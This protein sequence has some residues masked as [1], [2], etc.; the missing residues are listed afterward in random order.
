M[1]A[2]IAVIKTRRNL[3]HIPFHCITYIDLD[4]GVVRYTE[5]TFAINLIAEVEKITFLCVC[6]TLTLRKGI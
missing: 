5:G 6:D 4:T 1:K 2:Y 3:Y